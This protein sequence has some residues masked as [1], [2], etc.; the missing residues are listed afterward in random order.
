MNKYIEVSPDVRKE[1]LRAFKLTAGMVSLA[2]NF[3]ND[4]PTSE[5]VRKF[6]LQKGGV[7]KVVLDEKN[8]PP[9]Q[10]VY[11]RENAV[12]RLIFSPITEIVIDMK[13]GVTSLI[14]KNKVIERHE[15]L[16]VTE[17][18]QLQNRASILANANK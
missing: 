16:Y 9:Y 2:L 12:I 5:R 8:Q 11:D 3:K 10:N 15:K 7:V 6:A 14:D 18:L 13:T 17:L 4:S 1:I